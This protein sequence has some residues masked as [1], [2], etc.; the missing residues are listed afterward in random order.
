VLGYVV[1]GPVGLLLLAENLRTAA[2]LPGGHEIK[3]VTQSRWHR[4]TLQVW[5]QAWERNG[6]VST[7]SSITAVQTIAML[8]MLV[9]SACLVLL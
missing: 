9:A 3:T 4:I 7:I 2:V 1:L 5:Q 8:R 6:K